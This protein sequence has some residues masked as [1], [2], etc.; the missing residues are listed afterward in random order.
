MYLHQSKRAD[1][2][3]LALMLANTLDAVFHSLKLVSAG[4]VILNFSMNMLNLETPRLIDGSKNR[5]IE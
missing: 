3:C 1:Q 4:R 5:G 2:P